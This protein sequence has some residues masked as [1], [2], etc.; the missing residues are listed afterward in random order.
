[1]D[2]A[3]KA[4]HR[5][6]ENVAKIRHYNRVFRVVKRITVVGERR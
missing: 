2:T 6:L 3:N 5:T 4:L 1:M